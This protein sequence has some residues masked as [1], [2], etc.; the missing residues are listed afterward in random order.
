MTGDV[1]I[2][3]NGYLAMGGFDE[4]RQFHKIIDIMTRPDSPYLNYIEDIHVMAVSLGANGALFSGLYDT[5][6]QKQRIKSIVAMC[7]VVNLE[8][9]LKN[10]FS[11]KP[12]GKI[13]SLITY[14]LLKN[15]FRFVPILGELLVEGEFWSQAEVTNAVR[16]ASIRSY[17]RRTQK[18]P[19][20]LAPFEGVRI[21]SEEQFWDLNDFVKYA[22][23]VNVPSLVVHARDDFIVPSKVNADL[24][25]KK[26]AAQKSQIAILEL[27]NGSHCA[28]NV[29]N[30][31]PT[32]STLLR[33]FVLKYSSYKVQENLEIRPLQYVRTPKKS[34]NLILAQYKWLFEDGKFKLSMTYLDKTK[35]DERSRPTCMRSD[36]RFADGVFCY[37]TYK[38]EVKNDTF[39]ILGIQVPQTPRDADV[40]V[41]WLNT[42]VSPVSSKGDLLYG[43][44]EVP[45]H[46]KF[47]T[48]F[49]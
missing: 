36:Y 34:P 3:D 43:Q 29:A 10:V 46:I 35:K 20:D 2:K 6:S 15:V 25:S 49:K 32:I 27:R 23:N 9:S 19:W 18:T 4:G 41:R 40:A 33:E 39:L 17:I 13:Y 16:E 5:Y 1:F 21:E 28:F 7:P 47:Q 8:N 30:G 48:H 45:T 42:H 14:N 44:T 11:D 12:V 37:T 22:Q 38:F 24:L 26:L 31:W